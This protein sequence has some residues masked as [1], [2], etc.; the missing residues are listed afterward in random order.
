MKNKDT[1]LI[2]YFAFRAGTMYAFCDG[3]ACVIAG[4]EKALK[5][6]IIKLGKGEIKGYT[7]KKTRY[8]EILKGLKM[9]AAYAFDK[10]AYDVFYPLAKDGGLKMFELFRSQDNTNIDDDRIP[11]KRIQWKNIT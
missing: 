4:S 3:D 11:L 10:E 7:I 8:G 9:G 5:T 2:G 1:K 6:Y